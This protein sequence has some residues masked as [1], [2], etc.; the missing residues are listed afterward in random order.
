MA[1][2]KTAKKKTAKKKATTK[3]ATKE[4]DAVVAERELRKYIRRSG[5]FRKDLPDTDM[6]RAE[7]LMKALGR[8]QPIYDF[9]I[10][11]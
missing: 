9:T 2:K 11:R 8:T 3:L 5:G 7:K 1:K 4:F 6:A 10:L